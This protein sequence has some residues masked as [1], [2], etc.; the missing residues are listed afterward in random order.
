M[1][2]SGGGIGG[3]K[4]E[5]L[6]LIEPRKKWSSSEILDWL[7]VW[8][9]SSEQKLREAEKNLLGH[10][11]TPY[12]CFYINIGHVVGKSDR[13]WTLAMNTEETKHVPL[14]AL[15][16]RGSA[17]GS[18][19]L[20]LDALASQRPVFAIDM[21]GFGRSSRPMFSAKADLCEMQMVL[22][23]ELW[24]EEM[25]LPQMI[26]LGHCLG[27]FVATSYAL[28]YPH[29]VKHLILAEPWGFEATPSKA[30]DMLNLISSFLNPYWVL[31]SVGPLASILLNHTDPHPRLKEQFRA[32]L[33]DDLNHY[34]QQCKAFDP[35]GES[36]FQTLAQGQVSSHV[37]EHWQ[38]QSLMERTNEL[39]SNVGFTFICGT[40]S[41]MYALP[42]LAIVQGS[43]HYVHLEEPEEFNHHVLTIC[44]TI[45]V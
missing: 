11:A 28:A 6:P 33:E 2:A 32:L 34:L 9:L 14:V 13:I 4:T 27:A 26:L 25:R 35:S 45:D 21:L 36:A 38:R 10:L 37:R 3:K 17:L 23:L 30:L 22:A 18:W 8:S 7:F 40:Q 15:H 1:A 39:P 29:R 44:H 41:P 5:P 12:Q 43:G 16:G 42:H 31:W 20:N 19:L 24:R